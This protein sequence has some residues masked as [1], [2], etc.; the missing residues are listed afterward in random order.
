MKAIPLEPKQAELVKVFAALANPARIKILEILAQRPESIVADI[1][2]QLPLA[3]ST[4]SQHLSVLQDAGLIF[5]EGAGCGRCCR[6]DT[7]TLCWLS[8]D[9]VGWAM[10]LAATSGGARTPSPCS[11]GACSDTGR[12]VEAESRLVSAETFAKS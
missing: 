5:D 12:G 6:I 3:Q 1:V 11:R 4:V 9:V 7:E 8:R 10:R 2:E